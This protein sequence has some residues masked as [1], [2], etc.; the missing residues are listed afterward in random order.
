[1]KK[2]IL[3]FAL[4]LSVASTVFAEEVQID[5]LWYN[6][7]GTTA[8]VIQ[9]KSDQYS[10]DIVIPSTVSYNDAEYSV[11]SIEAF[12]FYGCSSLTSIEIPN[13]VTSIGYW[14]FDYCFSLTS[15][16]IPSSVTSIDGS[17]LPS[18][19]NITSIVVEEGNTKY[20]SRNN[21]NAIIE[22]STNTLIAGCKNTTIP[23]SVTSIGNMAFSGSDLTSI[24]IPSSV[25]SINGRFLSGCNNLTSIVVEE[26]NPK[27]DSRNNC[28]AI[29]ET[30]TNKLIAGCKNT[31]IPNSVTSIG[32]QAFFN[33]S[34][35]TEITI[36]NSVTSIGY[37][38]FM[39]CM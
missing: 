36:P 19:R 25:T 33:L 4:M 30:S 32:E 5:G 2:Q 18:C 38:A 22:T 21:C 6:L 20:D 10:G 17:I 24:T 8:E 28:N 9:S 37:T 7:E 34:S 11:T 14:A 26:G 35:L 12:A 16:T 29:I 39:E 31:T 27:Y 13:S 15:I 23:N 1:M 3:L